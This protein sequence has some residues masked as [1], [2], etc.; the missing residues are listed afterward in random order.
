M[1]LFCIIWS[2]SRHHRG[3]PTVYYDYS[4]A[5]LNNAFPGL[6]LLAGLTCKWLGMPDW[7]YQVCLFASILLA[8]CLAVYAAVRI[9]R[10]ALNVFLSLAA[11][12]TFIT[13]FY[14]VI[15]FLVLSFFVRTKRDYESKVQADARNRRKRKKHESCLRQR[16][17]HI[18]S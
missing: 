7:A 15:I 5:A 17:W 2:I 1:G 12:L 8:A 13:F 3:Q 11:C 10:G 4:D 9:N 18:F 14:A 6:G 16:P